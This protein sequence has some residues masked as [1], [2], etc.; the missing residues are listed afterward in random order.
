M[1]PPF[2]IYGENWTD[3]FSSS[4]GIGYT[5]TKSSNIGRLNVDKTHKY[6]KK[7]LELEL[8]GRELIDDFSIN[9]SFYHNYRTNSAIMFYFGAE[10]TK[11]FAN[12]YGNK[13][14]PN[15]YAVGIKVKVTELPKK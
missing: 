14:I 13:I 6:A 10:F 7:K 5:Y 12:A 3:G 2:P 8:T 1:F 4:F 9:I 15:A 11:V